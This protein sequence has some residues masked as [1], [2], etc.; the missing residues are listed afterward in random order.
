MSSKISNS[1]SLSLSLAQNR[2]IRLTA[3]P[4][5]RPQFVVV[6]GDLTD[7]KDKKRI[8][9]QQYVDEWD[10]YQTAIKE[11]VKVDW[12]D[13]RGNH[14]CFD[15]PSWQSRV[16]Y[17]RTHGHSAALIEQGKGVY[18]WQVNQPTGKYQFVAIDAW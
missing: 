4:F 13:M 2:Y 9:S 15:L 11:K 18:S 16:N 10:V 3:L 1:V 8:T 6:T 12:Y 5:D 17:Y 7:A 14:D